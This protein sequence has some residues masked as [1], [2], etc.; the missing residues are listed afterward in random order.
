MNIYFNHMHC[1]TEI[2]VSRHCTVPPK[3]PTPDT[4]VAIPSR[5]RRKR[6]LLSSNVL[7]GHATLP[8]KYPTP[9]T[10]RLRDRR[11]NRAT[12]GLLCP[13]TAVLDS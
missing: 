13:F 8:P 11:N 12:T 6:F 5:A 4:I 2:I 10:R 7:R 3:Y 9:D 1:S